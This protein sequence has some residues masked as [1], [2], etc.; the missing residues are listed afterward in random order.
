MGKLDLSKIKINVL[1]KNDAEIRINEYKIFYKT[2]LLKISNRDEVLGKLLVLLTK[3]KKT[4]PK[5]TLVLDNH[6]VEIEKEVKEIINKY[7]NTN[8]YSLYNKEIPTPEP[9]YKVDFDNSF[10]LGL[11]A[12]LSNTFENLNEKYKQEWNYKTNF[13]AFLYSCLSNYGLHSDI[14]RRDPQLCKRY[15]V[16]IEHFYKSRKKNIDYTLLLSH[17]SLFNDFIT[18]YEKQLHI[19]I[20]GK[21]IPFK[22]IYSIKFTS[23]LLLDDEI[24]LLAIKNSFQWNDTKKDD[25]KFIECCNDETNELHKNPYLINEKE[26]FRN[27]NT[28]FINPDRIIQ[29]EAVKNAAFDLTKLIGLCIELNN[30]SANKNSISASLLV[31]AIIDHVPPIFGSDNFAMLANNYDG[32]KSFKKAM[33]N[34]NNSLRNI[35]DIN[36]HSQIRNKE[37]LPTISQSDFTPELDLLLSE[38]YRKLK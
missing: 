18:P 13:I 29:L 33:L 22:D 28:Y 10:W 7:F 27:E 19:K 8:I 37:V 26:K 32:G 4:D 14:L 23:T 35:A 16:T 11:L 25:I 1:S 5:T 6:I 21:L 17:E 3:F 12:T 38:V 2:H 20:N 15:N 9:K 24:E 30:N 34:L 36:I 31:R